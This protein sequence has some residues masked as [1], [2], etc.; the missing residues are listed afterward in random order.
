VILGKKC[1]QERVKESTHKNTA[2]IPSAAMGNPT[3]FHFH[4]NLLA[5]IFNS[6]YQMRSKRLSQTVG[7]YRLERRGHGPCPSTI[8][9]FN[10]EQQGNQKKLDHDN[11]YTGQHL[12][13][14]PQDCKP[15]LKHDQQAAMLY[16]AVYYCQCSTCFE[17]FFHSS[18][19]A[20]ICTCSISYF[21]NL[22]AVTATA[23]TANK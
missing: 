4:I 3:F 12:N 20:V 18:S 23:V 17:R 9:V 8:L 15:I 10:Y 2:V 14:V 5:G 1:F 21:S 7:R 11:L 16:N 19:G 13:C 6:L 22:F